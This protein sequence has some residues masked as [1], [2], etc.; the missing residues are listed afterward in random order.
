MN[1]DKQLQLTQRM[2]A[3][4]V[5]EADIEES[6]VRS[7]GHGGQNVNKVSTCV[8]L[9]HRPTGIQVKCQETRQQALNRFL[10]RRL[11]V[12]KIEARQ[13]G[14]VAADRAEREKIRRQKRKRS[15]RAKARMLEAKSK[16]SAKKESRR[17]SSW[18]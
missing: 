15:R 11:L 16:H 6:F 10:A 1:P 12:D 5:R 18:D 13:R 7:G 9:L 17:A 14:F 3:L 8:M 4:G 2:T